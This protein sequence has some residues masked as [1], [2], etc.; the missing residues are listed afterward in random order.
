MASNRLPGVVV[1]KPFVTGNA[2]FLLAK[3]QKEGQASHRWTV[4]I[5]GLHN[6]D[7]SSYI[8]EVSFTLHESFREPVRGELDLV[9]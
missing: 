7:M 8:K 9:L 3:E 5:R 6:E 2:A 4:Y 1:A